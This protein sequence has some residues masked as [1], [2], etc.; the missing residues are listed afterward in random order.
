LARGPGHRQFVVSNY[1]NY[2]GDNPKSTAREI[3]KWLDSGGKAGKAPDENLILSVAKEYGQSPGDVEN[4]ESV[5]FERAV[6]KMHGEGI[7]AERR[8]NDLKKKTRR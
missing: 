3:A 2:R 4:W 1:G 7:D 6:V 8:T 5:W